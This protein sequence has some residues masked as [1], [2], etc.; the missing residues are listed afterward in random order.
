MNS[1][2]WTSCSDL[3][4]AGRATSFPAA[5]DIVKPTGWKILRLSVAFSVCALTTSA[6]EIFVRANQVGYGPRDAKVAIAFSHAAFSGRFSVVEFQ[7]GKTAFTGR[8]RPM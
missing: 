4:V 1:S 3:G 2:G 7:T 5:T 6:D 8:L